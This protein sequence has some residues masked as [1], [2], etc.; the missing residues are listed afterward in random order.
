MARHVIAHPDTGDRAVVDS[1]ALPQWQVRG[2]EV[3]PGGPLAEGADGLLTQQEWADELA[4][5]DAQI[6]AA[7]AKTTTKRKG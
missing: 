1:D 7:L 4:S 2:F 3:V 5:R 6:K